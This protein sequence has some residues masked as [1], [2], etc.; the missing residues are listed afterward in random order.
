MRTKPIV[1]VTAGTILQEMRSLN[2]KK[3][4]YVPRPVIDAIGRN[5]MIPIVLPYFEYGEVD[6]FISMFDGL[7]LTGGANPS[8]KFYGEEPIWSLGATNEKRDLFE[9]P[10]IQKTIAAKKPILAI[11]RGIQIMNVAMGGTLWQDMSAQKESGSF[12]QHMQKFDTSMGHWISFEKGSELY[13]L[14]GEGM[15]VNSRHRESVKEVAKGFHVV[16][17]AKDNMVE[18]IESDD[19]LHIGVQWHPENMEEA[20]DPLFV[21]F[22]EKVENNRK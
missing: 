17:R 8:P 2:Q 20:M 5:G 10:L 19:H 14:F 6:D 21:H 1:A 3:A 16:A 12:V 9:I 13:D 22:R 7:V 11:C 18:A 4:D 15:Y